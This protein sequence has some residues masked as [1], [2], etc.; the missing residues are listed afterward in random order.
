MNHIYYNPVTD[1]T[2]LLELDTHIAI[3]SVRNKHSR[4]YLNIAPT[5]LGYIFIGVL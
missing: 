5:K 2:L 4:Y 3:V 1:R